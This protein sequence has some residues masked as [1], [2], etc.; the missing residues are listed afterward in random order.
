MLSSR[1]PA[2]LCGWR[3]LQ[4]R[5]KATEPLDVLRLLAAPLEHLAEL[6]AGVVNTALAVSGSPKA[7]REAPKRPPA[8]AKAKA[9]AAAG[10]APAAAE[11]QRA[12]EASA[13]PSATGS[14][15]SSSSSDSSRVNKAESFFWKPYAPD[16]PFVLGREEFIQRLLSKQHRDSRHLV[17]D[18]DVESYVDCL[19]NEGYLQNVAL[20]ATTGRPLYIRVVRIVLRVL[21]NACNLVEGRQELGKTF[22]ILKQ[23]SKR[24]KLGVGQQDLDPKFI[25]RLAKRVVDDHK[26]TSP[27]LKEMGIPMPVVRLLY[28]DIIALSYRLVLDV[29]FSLEFR[30]L[31]HSVTLQVT[32]DAAICDAPGWDVDLA[33]GVFG[34]FEAEEKRRYAEEF[35]NELMLDEAVLI[36]E[37][38]VT[39]QREVYMRAVLVQL[40]LAETALNHFRVH[41]AGM[42]FRPALM[43]E[44]HLGM[45]SLGMPRNSWNSWTDAV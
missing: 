43:P 45:G 3:A 31:G 39:L 30:I 37:L 20:P 27:Y 29:C 25:E 9:C 41:V 6:G 10:H 22:V 34:T 14:S 8:T 12:A 36:K 1:L 26:E 18:E 23:S 19:L 40:N 7:F 24:S 42:S 17:P 5:G 35:V 2:R 15:S 33:S 38:P 32:P 16:S 28:Q 44:S 4:A 11:G 13:A 21:L